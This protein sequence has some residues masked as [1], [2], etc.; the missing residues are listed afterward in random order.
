[1]PRDDVISVWKDTRFSRR[2]NVF[3]CSVTT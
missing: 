1:M 3:N 2:A